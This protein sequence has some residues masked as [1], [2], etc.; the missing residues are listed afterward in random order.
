MNED[1]PAANRAPIV[2]DYKAAMTPA[3]RALVDEFDQLDALR[4][5]GVL[6]EEK[7]TRWFLLARAQDG[8][9]YRA[10]MAKMHQVSP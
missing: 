10:A 4:L 5:A 1:I 8:I 7:Q 6:P 3:E 9:W 2:G